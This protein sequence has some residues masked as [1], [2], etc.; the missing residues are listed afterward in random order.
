MGL[1]TPLL[2][3]DIP[4]NIFITKENAMHSQAVMRFHLKTGLNGSWKIKKRLGKKQNAAKLM[5]P[6]DSTG[7]KITNQFIDVFN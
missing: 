3:S 2:C 5:S 1:G 7:K 4:E 6:K